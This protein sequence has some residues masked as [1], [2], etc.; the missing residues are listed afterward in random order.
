MIAAIDSL[1]K[2]ISTPARFAAY[3]MLSAIISATL[4]YADDLPGDP[5]VASSSSQLK[6]FAPM[7]GRERLHNYLVGLASYQPILEAA[8][9][10]GINQAKDTPKEWAGGADGYGKRF[11]SAYAENVIHRTLQYGMSAA[12]HEDN[13]YFV[14]GETGFFRRTKYA[15]K[16]TFLARHDNGN[17]SFSYSRIGSAAGSAFISRAWQPRSTT[18]VEDG[19]VSFGITMAV[20]T[21]FNVM[22]EFWPDLNRHLRKK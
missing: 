15:V 9:S 6:Q 5:H 2:R 7:T 13:R 1:R 20:D 21:G 8:A 17:Q 4:V 22:R 10:A 19:A 18:S 12:L 14:S 11:G 3:L 16:S